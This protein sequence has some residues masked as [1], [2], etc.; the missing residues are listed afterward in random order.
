MERDGTGC[1]HLDGLADSGHPIAGGGGGGD[2]G[3]S[4]AWTRGGV[5]GGAS[6]VGASRRGRR[7][8]ALAVGLAVRAEGAVGGGQ[9]GALA[10]GTDH[11][12]GPLQAD[13][14]QL[15]AGAVGKAVGDL[16]LWP[17]LKRSTPALTPCV[18]L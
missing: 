2:D 17:D 11:G 6:G 16:G 12:G 15:L 5:L 9:R 3:I 14:L 13:G 18:C 1:L 8:V 7:G 4:D 10:L